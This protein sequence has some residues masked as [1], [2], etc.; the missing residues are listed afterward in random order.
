MRKGKDPDLNLWLMDPDPGGP[1]TCGS[2]KT[3]LITI[4]GKEYLCCL[5]LFSDTV[6]KPAETLRLASARYGS[7]LVRAPNSRSGGHDFECP[8][9]QKLV[10]LRKSGQ[11]LGV[12]SFYNTALYVVS[13][14]KAT[15]VLFFVLLGTLIKDRNGLPVEPVRLLPPAPSR[16]PP[17]APS[18][19]FPA[20][21]RPSTTPEVQRK[22][23]LDDLTPRIDAFLAQASASKRPK[24]EEETAADT[25][26]KN[27][28]F[29]TPVTHSAASPSSPLSPRPVD[30]RT[31]E[32]AFSV[33]K[34]GDAWRERR[35]ERSPGN[36]VILGRLDHGN[37]VSPTIEYRSE[38][39]HDPLLFNVAQEIFWLSSERLSRSTLRLKEGER[40]ICPLVLCSLSTV[41]SCID[42]SVRIV[43]KSPKVGTLLIFSI[44]LDA[45][46]R[47]GSRYIELG[48]GLSLVAGLRIRIWIQTH[49]FQD[50]QFWDKSYMKTYSNCGSRE[51]A[52]FYV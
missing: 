3:F 34:C 36:A 7:H 4:G 32:L 16:P 12:R 43:T 10:V 31:V 30:K 50:Q 33:G 17:S 23:K 13:C 42:A 48:C 27:P 51:N 9:R 24:P 29:S 15:K 25:A 14:G 47:F 22:R 19:P 11:T 28:S 8:V 38:I 26:T 18:R 35:P 1:K 45:Y 2:Q 40:E 49:I 5:F 6:E 44:S 37:L 41:T 20:P 46:H 52:I 21:S 39:T